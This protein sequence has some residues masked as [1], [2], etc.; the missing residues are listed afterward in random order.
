MVSVE[1][2]LFRLGSLTR[3][4]LVCPVGL[5]RA[6]PVDKLQDLIPDE[7]TVRDQISAVSEYREHTRGRRVT[8]PVPRGKKSLPTM[9]FS[10]IVSAQGRTH[11]LNNGSHLQ[12]TTL[13]TTL[14]TDDC[15]LRQILWITSN[16]HT[17]QPPSMAIVYLQCCCSLR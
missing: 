8:I 14:R 3:L 11:P 6:D 16:Q 13:T 7:V 4:V 2:A 1:D 5:T 12:D 15:D 9:F 17:L 10:H